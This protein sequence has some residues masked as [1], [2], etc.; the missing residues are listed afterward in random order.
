MRS[1]RTFWGQAGPRAGRR[2]AFTLMELLVVIAI[3]ALLLA[4]LLPAVHAVRKQAAAMTCQSHLRQWGILLDT[5]ATANDGKF[6]NELTRVDAPTEFNAAVYSWW[7]TFLTDFGNYPDIW[8][9]PM[10]TAPSPAGP[11]GATFRAWCGTSGAVRLPNGAWAHKPQ[12]LRGSYGV[13]G[14]V[15]LGRKDHPEPERPDAS[16]WTTPYVREAANAPLVFDC[17]CSFYCGALDDPPPYE[18]ADPNSSYSGGVCM[19][20]HQGGINSVFMDWSVRK[21][22]LKQLW[23]LRWWVDYDTSNPWTIAGGVQPADWPAWM[24]RFKD[25]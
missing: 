8:L 24:R 1:G 25:N 16:C 18:D 7:Y 11:L 2:R 6:F 12:E 3:I 22:G 23:S 10:A 20:R 17:R 14:W 21:V 4:L 15:G 19:N 5:Y 13:N 9:C